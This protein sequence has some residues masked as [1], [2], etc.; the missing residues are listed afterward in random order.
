MIP[1]K[2]INDKREPQRLRAKGVLLLQVVKMV[3]FFIYK[4]YTIEP[5]AGHSVAAIVVPSRRDELFGEEWMRKYS[6]EE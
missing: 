6:E 4:K 2:Q 3:I 5:R 1:S